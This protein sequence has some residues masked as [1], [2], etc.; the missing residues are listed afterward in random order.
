MMEERQI[1]DFSNKSRVIHPSLMGRDTTEREDVEDTGIND[2]SSTLTLL[3]LF[4][5]T[6]S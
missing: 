6:S 1:P 5:P 3:S 4:S 2:E